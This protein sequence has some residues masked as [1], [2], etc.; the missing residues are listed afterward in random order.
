MSPSVVVVV[1]VIVVVITFPRATALVFDVMDAAGP[2]VDLQLELSPR[3]V[4]ESAFPF[5]LPV[6]I[7]ALDF[8]HAKLDV[9]AVG[10]EAVCDRDG[11]L[12]AEGL[13]WWRRR[14][15][16][17]WFNGPG[18]GRRHRSRWPGFT[19]R[20]RTDDTA[21]GRESCHHDDVNGGSKGV[22]VS[23][24]PRSAP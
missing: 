6:A 16:R 18:S 3:S 5:D 24:R 10:G 8:L 13:G 21:H 20:S 11:V 23:C 1:I 19:D 15:L 7:V 4:A 14:R 22:H 17:C 2:G 12:L 9:S